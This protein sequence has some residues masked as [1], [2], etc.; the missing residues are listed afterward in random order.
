MRLGA[1]WVLSPVVVVLGV[2]LLL[3]IVYSVMVNGKQYNWSYN[4]SSRNP[5]KKSIL[6]WALC[7]HYWMY[8][9]FS[10]TTIKHTKLHNYKRATAHIAVCRF[11]YR[12]FYLL[13]RNVLHRVLLVMKIMKE[14]ARG[15]DGRQLFPGWCE[16]EWIRSNFSDSRFTFF[17]LSHGWFCFLIIQRS[18]PPNNN[19]Y[20]VSPHPKLT[21]KLI[22]IFKS[23]KINFLCSF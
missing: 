19:I 14:K 17:I 7:R 15:Q 5:Q 10:N 1:F 16:S 18:F 21:K 12:W 4:Y 13:Y 22:W 9:S 3:Y 20:S 23:N 8:C 11:I 6:I 2:S